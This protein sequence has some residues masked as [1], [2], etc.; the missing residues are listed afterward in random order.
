MVVVYRTLRLG[1][2]ARRGLSGGYIPILVA[3]SDE[4][5]I[6]PLAA[7]ARQVDLPKSPTECVQ[8][9]I[10]LGNCKLVCVSLVHP[11]VIVL[12]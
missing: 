2:L 3:L 7:I 10:K 1:A 5:R 6:R 8:A 4:R 11:K 9:C 12:A